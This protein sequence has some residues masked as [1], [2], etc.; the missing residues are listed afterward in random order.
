MKKDLHKG[1]ALAAVQ[2]AQEAIMAG[3]WPKAKESME[4]ALVT[5]EA[6]LRVR[7]RG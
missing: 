4:V 3:D 5:A 1:L 2:A 6:A 7:A